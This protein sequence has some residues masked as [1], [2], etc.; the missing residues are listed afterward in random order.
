MSITLRKRWEIANSEVHVIYRY[1]S[2]YN[3]STQ[4]WSASSLAKPGLKR[5]RSASTCTHGKYSKAFT[6][7]DILVLEFWYGEALSLS[8]SC[9]L[10]IIQLI[11]KMAGTFHLWD[12][13][14]NTPSHT[15][16]MWTWYS[17]WEQHSWKSLAVD[18]HNFLLRMLN[19][20][21]SAIRVTLISY[22]RIYYL[23]IHN[24]RM[25]SYLY[26]KGIKPFL[27]F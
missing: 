26:Y 23:H 16:C 2:S 22:M 27:V 20:L 4:Y 18:T 15:V 21:T 5:A 19:A 7:E 24:S 9:V 8:E 6:L 13:F 11:Y 17:C 12:F 10:H 14:F 3:Y 25:P 1:N